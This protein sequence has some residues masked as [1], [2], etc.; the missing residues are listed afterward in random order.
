MDCDLWAKRTGSILDSVFD[1]YSNSKISVGGNGHSFYI[2][3]TVYWL[4]IYFLTNYCPDKCL[5]NI[6]KERMPTLD[7]TYKR[8]HYSSVYTSYKGTLQHKTSIQTSTSMLYQYL[9][10]QW[11]CLDK[12]PGLVP[13]I[14]SNLLIAA[15]NPLGL[16]SGLVFL[17]SE[18]CCSLSEMI[19]E[20]E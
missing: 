16:E 18:L 3:Y 6:P 1:L 19:I 2:A 14:Y 7:R 5:T 17:M 13:T 11:V 12:G 9:F 10:K 20:W 4:L 15:T 8:S